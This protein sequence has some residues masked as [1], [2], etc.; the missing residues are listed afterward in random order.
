MIKLI[1]FS[2]GF[3]TGAWIALLITALIA[4]SHEEEERERRYWKDK[5]KKG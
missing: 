3:L 2:F 5:Q 4:T 1:I